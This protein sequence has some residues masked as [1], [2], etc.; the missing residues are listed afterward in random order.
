MS[1]EQAMLAMCDAFGYEPTENLE[2]IAKV[3]EKFFG[4]QGWRACPCDRCNAER[5]CISKLCR[6]EIERDGQCHCN[7]YRKRGV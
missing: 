1:V 6:E 3:K 2:K 7:A 4:E 5:F